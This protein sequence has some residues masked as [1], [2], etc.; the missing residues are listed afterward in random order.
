MSAINALLEYGLF[1]ATALLMGLIYDWLGTY[2]LGLALLCLVAAGSVLLTIT[3]V[4]STGQTPP[5]R[6]AGSHA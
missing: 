4:R 2:A 5:T 3:G 6:R 1:S